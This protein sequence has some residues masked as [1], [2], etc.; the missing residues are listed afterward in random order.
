MLGI[1]FRFSGGAMR[2]LNHRVISPALKMMIMMWWIYKVCLKVQL[3]AWRSETT[4]RNWF[5]LF[6]VGSRMLVWQELLPTGNR[7]CPT[8]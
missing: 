2:A 6:T 3:S 7:T 4:F 5:S 1:K 8:L